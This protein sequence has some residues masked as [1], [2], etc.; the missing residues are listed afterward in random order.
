MARAIRHAW[1]V[2]LF[3]FEHRRARRITIEVN[4]EYP[5]TNTEALAWEWEM[6]QREERETHE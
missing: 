4:A 3:A 1:A 6:A 5:L 2:L